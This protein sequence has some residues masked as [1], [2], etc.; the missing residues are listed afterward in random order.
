MRRIHPTKRGSAYLL[1]AVVVLVVA[2]SC[3]G[4]SGSHAATTTRGTTKAA[5]TTTTA[6]PVTSTSESTT[7]SSSLPVQTLPTV[8]PTSAT[9][10]PHGTTPSACSA[11]DNDLGKMLIAY[12]KSQQPTTPV[13]IEHIVHAPSDSTWA[14][15]DIVPLAGS[16]DTLIAVVHCVGV[17]WTVVDS[18]TSQIGCAAPVPAAVST[19]IGF[20]C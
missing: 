16:F 7:T 6:E 8:P 2:A 14:R 9:T 15:A 5:A 11:T 3:G 18:G 10:A 1:G 4:S 13:N 12:A 20:D 19:E 17:Q